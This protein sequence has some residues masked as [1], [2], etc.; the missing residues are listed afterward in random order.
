[1]HSDLHP[2]N[3]LFHTVRG[4]GRIVLV[5]AGMVARL[6]DDE[7]ENF[8]GLLE[9][10]GQGDGVRAA[11]HVLSFSTTQTCTGNAGELFKQDMSDVGR[12]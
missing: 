8:I 3:I 6:T 2:G 5:D 10:L 1:M 7:R 11:E 9:A 12:V 4:D